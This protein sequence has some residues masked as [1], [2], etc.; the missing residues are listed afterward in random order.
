[1]TELEDILSKTLDHTIYLSKT[2]LNNQ[3]IG[4]TDAQKFCVAPLL[5]RSCHKA[6]SI[7]VLVKERL[8][9]EA[10]TMLRILIE[11]NFVVGALCKESDFTREYGRSA[12]AQKRPNL[13]IFSMDSS[14]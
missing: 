1:M 7:N 5:I 14:C 13:K 12:W 11:V 2:Y 10:E 9:E 6:H 3:S 8:I 4:P